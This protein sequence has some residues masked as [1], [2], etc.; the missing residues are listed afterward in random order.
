MRIAG[1]SQSSEFY[2]IEEV[3]AGFGAAFSLY[4]SAPRQFIS[5]PEDIFPGEKR[6]PVAD[7]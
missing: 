6:Q 4:F 2:I 3:N 7:K 5:D 1:N